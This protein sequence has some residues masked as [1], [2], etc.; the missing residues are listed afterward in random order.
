MVCA[1][2]T[3]TQHGSATSLHDED[4]S[5]MQAFLAWLTA[6]GVDDLQKEKCKLGVYHAEKGERGMLSLQDIKAGTVLLHLP[7]RLAITDH[8]A[9][10]ESNEVM[11]EDAP[12]SLRLACKL[13]REKAKG[14]ASPY[15]PYLQVLPEHVPSPLCT[16]AWEDMPQIEVP[17]MTQQLHHAS[18]LLS[19]A[20][21]RLSPEA[22]GGASREELE[23]AVSVV[24]SRT[25]GTAAKEGGTAVH[26]LLPLVDFLNHGGD[27]T[28]CFP[29][30]PFAPT[31]NVR[32][33]LVAPPSDNPSE[34]FQM[35]LVARQDI[36]EGQEIL[37]SYGDR[38]NDDFFLHYGFVPLRNPHDDAVLFQDLTDALDWHYEHFKPEG[39]ANE[40]DARI[41]YQAAAEAGLAQAQPP[42]PE[43]H[44]TAAMQEQEQ[45]LRVYPGAL[46]DGR[47]M[48]AFQHLVAS[49]GQEPKKAE[50]AV[51]ARC[52]QLLA[53]MSPLPDDLKAL[54]ADP[55]TEQD[56]RWYYV[57]AAQHYG[58]A[59]QKHPQTQV[60]V[61]AS[62]S[63]VLAP[64]VQSPA[65]AQQDA[66]SKAHAEDD[67]PGITT[68][69]NCKNGST[70]FWASMRIRQCSNGVLSFHGFVSRQH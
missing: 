66:S 1:T 63:E 70:R 9:D 14:S 25:F 59:I 45:K 27:E 39:L 57:T 50:A 12:W 37:L 55:W 11:F 44:L 22:T 17:D 54:A 51:A 3:E 38:N 52:Q 26:M 7:L 10:P 23:W 68:V 58:V 62:T 18:W 30:D 29:G 32:W 53:A 69:P 31:A 47:L 43:D 24:H 67:M 13:L 64:P 36:P 40:E 34:G 48:A 41:L 19:D 21:P 6:Q 65:L 4:P 2:L 33:H 56:D 16:F 49:Q 35:H 15:H 60:L 5:Q 61:Q 28:E 8:P 42:S 46:V 20:W